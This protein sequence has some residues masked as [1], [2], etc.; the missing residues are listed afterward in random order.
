MDRQGK[1]NQERLVSEPIAG[2]SNDSC[3]E[4]RYFESIAR[5][6]I[7]FMAQPLPRLAFVSA[8]RGSLASPQSLRARYA[9]AQGLPFELLVSARAVLPLEHNGRDRLRSPSCR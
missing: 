5:C 4:Y 3:V 9:S 2:Q 7:R 8:T 1:V 6:A